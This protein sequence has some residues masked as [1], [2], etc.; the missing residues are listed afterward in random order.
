MRSWV[1]SATEGRPI[2]E[3][4]SPKLRPRPAADHSPLKFMIS[5]LNSQYAVTT[6]PMTKLAIARRKPETPRSRDRAATAAIAT[7][8]MPTS[9]GL[10]TS[11]GK[12]AGA[13]TLPSIGGGATVLMRLK[14]KMVTKRKSTI[15]IA[16]PATAACRPQ[17]EPRKA[18]IASTTDA[19]PAISD[20][21]G[22]HK[23]AAYSG[24]E[25]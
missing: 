5:K 8:A 12:L 2:I 20:I 9:G 4:R 17:D 22:A 14:A 18:M 1:S 24:F 13:T 16:T 23:Y 10:S 6:P 21:E 3:S 15:P 19:T 25:L 7:P 11:K